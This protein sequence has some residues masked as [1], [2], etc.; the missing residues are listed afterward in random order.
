MRSI[1]KTHYVV[2]ALG[3]LAS[4]IAL[5]PL[6][7]APFR[8]DEWYIANFARYAPLTVETLAQASSWELFGDP[9]FQPFSH[10]LLF[11]IHKMLGNAFV[12]FHLLSWVSHIVVGL[13]IYAIVRELHND[14]LTASLCAVLFILGFS[15]FDTVS[16]TYH[17]YIIHQAIC[18]L[19]G[20]WIV[21]KDPVALRWW[22]ALPGGML[23]GL[24]CYFYEAA[25]VIPVL[26]LILVFRSYYLLKKSDPESKSQNLVLFALCVTVL[27]SGFLG[28]YLSQ[29][30]GQIS[31]RLDTGLFSAAS[32][33]TLKGLWGQG[34]IGN[35]G[36]SPRH[37]VGDLLYLQGSRLGIVPMCTVILFLTALAIR[38]R[39]PGSDILQRMKRD[40]YL[41][42]VFLG[43]A[44]SYYGIIAIGR[45]NLYVVTQSRYFYLPDVFLVLAFSWPLAVACS[46]SDEAPIHGNSRWGR[47]TTALVRPQTWAVCS[48]CAVCLLNAFHVFGMCREI[49]RIVSPVEVSIENVKR[50]SQTHAP[51]NQLY[52]DFVPRNLDDKLFGGTDIALETCFGDRGLLTRHVWRARY[53]YSASDGIVP[54][55]AF[56]AKKADAGD[57]TLEFDYVMWGDFI[58]V[59]H[60]PQNTFCIR[61]VSPAEDELLLRFTF[62]GDG[63]R[64]EI[65][66]I[67]K[68]PRRYVSHVVVQKQGGNIYAIEEGRVIAVKRVGEGEVLWEDETLFLGSRVVFPP[69]SC[70]LENFFACVG[71]AKYDLEGADIGDII[72]GSALRA[73]MP[74]LNSDPLYWRFD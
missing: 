36:F 7:S 12:L 55:R 49:A 73:P 42:G 63:R 65:Y 45:F 30:G 61:Q 25:L 72:P 57:F 22:Q 52:V 53:I 5:S 56:G 35:S 48:V 9:R 66:M 2:L 69:Q 71:K 4:L 70:Y 44:V 26:I 68:H 64:Q 58:T 37:A 1:Y 33:N 31:G 24:A 20:F 74:A 23:V 60:S 32:V 46:G 16:W 14:K 51:G 50:F 29:M 18:L 10:L 41:I 27:F 3:M 11:L 40:W 8:N 47:L 62:L 54:N 19:F 39:S 17:L 28:L 59:I 6:L 43:C 21:L 34:V 15:H 67:A 13:L 38:L